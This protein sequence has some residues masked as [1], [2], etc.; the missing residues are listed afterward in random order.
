MPNIPIKVI[1]LDVGLCFLCGKLF[2][3]NKETQTD[4]LSKTINHGLP[5]ALKPK[6]N[7]N[8]PLHLECHKKLNEIY[9]STQRKPIE[10]KRLN[11]LKSRVEGLAGLSD[12]FDN[13]VKLILKQI[14][15]DFNKIKCS[16]Y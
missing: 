12:K 11:Y 2:S 1:K 8:F 4:P 5:K 10:K 7:V 14:N 15:E 3:T 6:F 13:R 9:V 16:S